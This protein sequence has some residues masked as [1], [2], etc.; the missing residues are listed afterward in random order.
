MIVNYKSKM[1]IILNFTVLRLTIFD[2]IIDIFNDKSYC[3][4]DP[5]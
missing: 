1:N 5:I 3:G 4:I 2:F